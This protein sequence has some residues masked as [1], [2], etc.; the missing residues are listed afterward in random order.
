VG[1]KQGAII[2]T[3]IMTTFAE[4]IS[5]NIAIVYYITELKH[6]KSSIFRISAVRRG[7]RNKRMLFLTIK[8]RN[9]R[10]PIKM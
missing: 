10:C 5:E 9:K 8:L 3:G 6:S 7:S 4:R 1:A 2:M